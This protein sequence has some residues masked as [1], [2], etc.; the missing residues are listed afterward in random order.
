MRISEI[1]AVEHLNYHLTGA[2]VDLGPSQTLL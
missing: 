1:F 2:M